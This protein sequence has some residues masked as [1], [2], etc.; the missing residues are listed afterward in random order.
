MTIDLLLWKSRE[1]SLVQ[2]SIPTD[3]ASKAPNASLRPSLNQ[4]A[5][6]F[7]DCGPFCPCSTAPHCLSHQAVI[8]I[9]VGTHPFGTSYV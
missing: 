2:V 9:D 8:D 3:L 1:T 5:Q 6:S 7:L 4:Q